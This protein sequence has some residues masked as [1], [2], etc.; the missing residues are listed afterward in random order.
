M[1]H[2][3]P[4]TLLLAWAVLFLFSSDA[5]STDDGSGPP[6]N[7]EKGWD[8]GCPELTLE[9]YPMDIWGR[10]LAAPDVTVTDAAGEVLFTRSGEAGPLRL[11]LPARGDSLVCAVSAT[12]HVPAALALTFHGGRSDAALTIGPPAA[13]SDPEPEVWTPPGVPGRAWSLDAGEVDARRCP[14]AT[15]YLGLDHAWFAAAGRPAREGNALRLLMDGEEAWAQAAQDLRRAR[16]RVFVSTWWWQSDFELERGPEQPSQD[17]EARWPKTMIR[18]LDGLP[19]EVTRRILVTRFLPGTVG[20]LEHVN[21]DTE[22]RQRGRD[23]A[24]GYEV[25]M[26]GNPTAIPYQG[27]LPLVLTPIDFPARIQAR[28]GLPPRTFLGAAAPAGMARQPLEADVATYHQKSLL[29]DDLVGYIGG[30]NVKSSD[31]DTS[32]HPVFEPRRMMFASPVA[33]RQAVAAKTRLPD[34]GPRKDYFLRFE[35][36]LVEDLDDLLCARWEVA[37]AEEEPYFANTT[38]CTTRPWSGAA[39]PGEVLAQVV[40]TLP[41]PL[42]EVSILE[43]LGKAIRRAERWIFIEDQYFR[44]PILNDALATALAE[45]P[46]L[47]LVVVTKPVSSADGGKRWT[48]ASDRMLREAGG[49]R[50][51]LFQLVTFDAVLEPPGGARAD[52]QIHWVPIDTHSKLV[53]VDDRYLTV[54]S[55]NKNNRGLKFEGELNVA[56]LDQG[57]VRAATQ[58]ILANLVGPGRAGELTGDP[59][60]DTALLEQVAAANT[61]RR[62]WWDEHGA[63]DERDA[64][65]AEQS[66]RWPEGFLFPLAFD[67]AV[68]FPEVGPDLF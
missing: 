12:D 36:P 13:G 42:H 48:L 65:E 35:G 63:T 11:P 14:V 47:Q 44:M 66:A 56:V 4:R 52:R 38:A 67:D 16:E 45:H 61:E 18:L 54:G 32:A 40:A 41:A 19:A 17:E 1:R 49:E 34:V 8:P 6:G 26:Q 59:A 37:R 64:V 9:L 46:A 2:T 22:L 51:H 68:D 31:W 50:Y 5:C 15:L 62:R 27:E 28:S 57:F 33:D 43:S 25:L 21:T 7:D 3:D 60:Q 10:P 53:I 58:R 29:I 20:G 39:L 30:M 23:P 24:S 55:C